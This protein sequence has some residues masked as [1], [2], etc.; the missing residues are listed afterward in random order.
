MLC[1]DAT[2][3]GPTSTTQKMASPVFILCSGFFIQIFLPVFKQTFGMDIYLSRLELISYL[4]QNTSNDKGNYA[5]FK[6]LLSLI[7]QVVQG[8]ISQNLWIEWVDKFND[9]EEEFFL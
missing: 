1:R 3:E 5:Y 9:Y 2:F 4:L 8:K 6:V 7:D